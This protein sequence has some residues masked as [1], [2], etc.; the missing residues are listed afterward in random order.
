MASTHSN[1]P[2]GNY[3]TPRQERLPR[4]LTYAQID[5]SSDFI[6][7][8]TS[9]TAND[10]LNSDFALFGSTPNP[11]FN[12]ASFGSSQDS[13]VSSENIQTVSPKD[14]FAENQS[15]PPSSAMTNLSTPQT[16]TFDSPGIVHST[17]TSPLFCEDE[18]D[19]D[20]ENWD[21][22]FPPDNATEL[23]SVI[24]RF[25]PAMPGASSSPGSRARPSSVVG[26][27]AR[28][29][30]KPLPPIDIDNENDPIVKK[31]KKN[32]EAARKSRSKKVERVEAMEQE[33]NVLKHEAEQY[34][35]EVSDLKALLAR[36]GIDYY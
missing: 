27:K 2:Y 10:S 34:K 9:E 6:D 31:R 20:A 36:H 23:Q 35:M 26:S 32:T 25:S 30:D 19:Q 12:M 21:S 16:Y 33:I 14:I 15:A 24:D 4:N 1:S 28:R 7:F 17:G 18:L 29:K 3:L 5:L 22:L 13:N 11:S 8:A